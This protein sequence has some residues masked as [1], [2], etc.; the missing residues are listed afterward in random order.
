MNDFI[1]CKELKPYQA[2]TQAM[3]MGA[4]GKFGLLDLVF[5]LDEIHHAA[6]GTAGPSDCPA[7]TVF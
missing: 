5:E 1:H 2:P 7:R 6:L 4:P 3:R